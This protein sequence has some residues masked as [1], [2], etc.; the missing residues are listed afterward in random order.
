MLVKNIATGAAGIGIATEPENSFD[1]RFNSLGPMGNI[2]YSYGTHRC[3]LIAK[4]LI[5]ARGVGPVLPNDDICFKHVALAFSDAGVEF[6]KPY[7]TGSL[8]S[9]IDSLM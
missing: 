7:H 4:G 2:Q 6:M 3:G 1:T 5:S 8:P 9:L